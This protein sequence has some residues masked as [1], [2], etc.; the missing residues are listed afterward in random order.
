MWGGA[1]AWANT[2]IGVDVGRGDECTAVVVAT[3]KNGHIYIE[4]VDI[5]EPPHATLETRLVPG[6][7]PPRYEPV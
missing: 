5:L 2:F 7:N 4:S 6:S 3:Q 1:I